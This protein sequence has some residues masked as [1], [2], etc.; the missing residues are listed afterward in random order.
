MR[1]D[2]RDKLFL[3]GVGALLLELAVIFLLVR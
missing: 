1:I 3:A 2:D